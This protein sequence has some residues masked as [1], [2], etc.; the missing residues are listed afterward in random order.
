MNSPPK[1]TIGLPFFNPGIH[2]ENALKSIFCQTFQDW[3]LILI[4]D[5]ST[6]G[7]LELV[8]KIQDS[9]VIVVHDGKN[10]G[11][12]KRLNQIT[13]MA[14]GQYI[15]RMDADDLMHPERIKKQIE[16]LE[17]DKTIDMIDCA[18]VI[19]DKNNTPTRIMNNSNQ[20]PSAYQLLKHG[21]FAHPTITGKRSWFQA[22]LYNED[23]IYKRS[24]DRELFT[25]T[26]KHTKWAHLCDILFF[27]RYTDN[28]R[29]KA[30][31]ES[32]AGER[33]VLLHY[34]VDLIGIISVIFL[35]IRSLLKSS[36]LQILSM[37][38]KEH[39]IAKYTLTESLPR[40][41]YEIIRNIENSKLNIENNIK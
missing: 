18:Y 20:I 11:L 15:A 5:G 1:V 40:E 3:E 34:G 33:R 35:Y 14:K 4:D 36:T 21:G 10:L 39:I 24:E 26:F 9:R 38:G 8:Q 16:F 19:L 7:S 2:F 37:F 31:L 17:K 22:N 28:V 25:R 32:Y 6:D 41:L 29:A 13:Q 27:Y 23:A 12:P 30:S